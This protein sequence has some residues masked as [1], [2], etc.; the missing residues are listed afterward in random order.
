MVCACCGKRARG[1][2]QPGWLDMDLKDKDTGQLDECVAFCRAE[3]MTTW[4]IRRNK[5]VDPTK[6]ELDALMLAGQA[7]GEYLE[8]LGRYDLSALSEDEWVTFL[9]CVISKY[10]DESIPF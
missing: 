4:I 9:S 2:T 1:P 7:G 5:M 8:S 6:P 10:Y 3:C